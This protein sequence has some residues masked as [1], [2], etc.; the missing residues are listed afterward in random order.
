MPEKEERRYCDG[1]KTQ[2]IQKI[3]VKAITAV[4]EKRR[5]ALKGTKTCNSTRRIVHLANK[6][7]LGSSRAALI[8]LGLN[9]VSGE[10]RKFSL[11]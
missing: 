8:V 6:G 1:K 4:W 2:Q 10:E 3:G 7:H 5:A 9:I 11:G